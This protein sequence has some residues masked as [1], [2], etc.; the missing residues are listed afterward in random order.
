MAAQTRVGRARGGGDPSAAAGPVGSAKPPRN[1]DP[2]HGT[3][4]SS[5]ERG[6]PALELAQQLLAAGARGG[7]LAK[8]FESAG[9]TALAGSTSGVATG[10]DAA[11]NAVQLYT[12]AVS[13]GGDPAS[14]APRRAEA[15]ALAGD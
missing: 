4:R 12:Q 11:A 7:D 5:L 8:V 15:A 2:L 6:R 10:P 14:L 3:A 1:A 9:D 13:A